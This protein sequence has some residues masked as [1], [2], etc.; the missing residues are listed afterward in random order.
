VH[1]GRTRKAEYVRIGLGVLLIRWAND[2][3][4]A[5]YLCSYCYLPVAK[6]AGNGITDPRRKKIITI[7]IYR[8]NSQLQFA[9]PQS[10]S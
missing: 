10:K 3:G 6:T 4:D 5:E 7:P 9:T 2:D 8:C 1:I